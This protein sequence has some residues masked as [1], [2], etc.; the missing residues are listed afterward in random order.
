MFLY[1]GFFSILSDLN[2]SDNMHVV[3]PKTIKLHCYLLNH[4]W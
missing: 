3:N 1:L 2:P 4:L